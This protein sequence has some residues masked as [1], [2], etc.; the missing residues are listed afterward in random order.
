MGK[1]NLQ[2]SYYYA[3]YF[4]DNF[5]GEIYSIKKN[6]Y[7]E[8][9]YLCVEIEDMIGEVDILCIENVCFFYPKMEVSYGL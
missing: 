1:C 3:K 4:L 8:T 6:N 2:I 7:N 9:L 5:Y